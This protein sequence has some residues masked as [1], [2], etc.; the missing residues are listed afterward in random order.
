MLQCTKGFIFSRMGL[1]HIPEG[2]FTRFD[3]PS[4]S[5]PPCSLPLEPLV[6]SQS[7]LY[8][9]VFST[10][11]PLNQISS[12]VVWTLVDVAGAYALVQTWR[13]RSGLGKSKRDALLAA[14]YVLNFGLEVEG[15]MKLIFVSYLFNPYLLLPSL[16]HST[17]S[18]SNMLHL[19]SV[20]FAARGQPNLRFHA[21]SFV[22]HTT[23]DQGRLHLRSSISRHSY[24]SHYHP[25]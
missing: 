4:L 5:Q 2:Y 11:L 16:A 3:R 22:T 6:S 9:S 12:P 17:S 10:F 13:A 23:T 19:L 7:P 18:I 15:L 14:L 20:M 21:L 1:I 24:R 8:L 25:S